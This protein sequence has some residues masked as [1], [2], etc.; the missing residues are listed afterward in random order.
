MKKR[1]VF[2]TGYKRAPP[3][4]SRCVSPIFVSRR[5]SNSQ[6]PSP[7]FFPCLLLVKRARPLS[8]HASIGERPNSRIQDTHSVDI[9]LNQKYKNKI[10][11]LFYLFILFFIFSYFVESSFVACPGR[12]GLT[13][14]LFDSFNLIWGAR[15][16]PMQRHKT[17][18]WKENNSTRSFKI[19]GYV[20]KVSFASLS[21]VPP[22]TRVFIFCAFFFI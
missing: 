4:Q 17:V 14:D 19:V 6:F 12:R 1:C 7:F 8:V 21:S 22:P 11:F 16:R 15:C 3:S 9:D 5:S 18:V 13:I 2:S 10:K 20:S